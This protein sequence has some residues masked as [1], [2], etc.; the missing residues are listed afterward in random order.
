M[1]PPILPNPSG[2]GI[3][4]YKRNKAQTESV[5]DAG[6]QSLNPGMML[7]GCKADCFSF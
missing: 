6:T 4:F 7:L 3:Q 5:S 2:N 1:H